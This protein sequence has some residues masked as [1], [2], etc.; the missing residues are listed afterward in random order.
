MSEEILKYN[1]PI[2]ESNFG[3]ILSEYEKIREFN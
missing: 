3:I 2:L 1:S